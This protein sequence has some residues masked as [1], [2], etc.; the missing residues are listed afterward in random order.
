M[1]PI[2]FRSKAMRFVR[3]QNRLHN[4]PPVYWYFELIEINYLC[5]EENTHQTHVDASKVLSPFCSPLPYFQPLMCFVKAI[6]YGTLSSVI[7]SFSKTKRKLK[8]ICSKNTSNC[9]Q[10]KFCSYWKFKWKEQFYAKL[11]I[12]YSSSTNFCPLSQRP[13]KEPLVFLY[14][15]FTSIPSTKKKRKRKETE[16]P[17]KRTQKIQWV[18]KIEKSTM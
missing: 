10:V 12:H 11:F 2:Q 1:F 17:P 8:G 14:Y 4:I 13:L 7:V 6:G 3:I 15:N 5:I 18:G 9:I 16:K